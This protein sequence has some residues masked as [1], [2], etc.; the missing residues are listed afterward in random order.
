M[1][2]G[3]AREAE[4]GVIPVKTMSEIWQHRRAS[5][6][7]PASACNRGTIAR[8]VQDSHGHDLGSGN[9]IINIVTIFDNA[10]KATP[11]IAAR[12]ARLLQHFT[13]R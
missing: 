4:Y 3:M 2:A 13:K 7:E 9:Y 6:G 8:S 10:P 5:A 12:R 11:N 1:P